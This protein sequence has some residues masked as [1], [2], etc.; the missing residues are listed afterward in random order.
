MGDAFEKWCEEKGG[1]LIVREIPVYAGKKEVPPWERRTIVRKMN[2]CLIEKDNVKMQFL[3][4][5]M[6]EEVAM[7]VNDK[8]EMKAMIEDI[9]KQFGRIG[10]EG[11]IEF[12]CREG[13]GQWATPGVSWIA[14][15]R[16]PVKGGREVGFFHSI[17]ECDAPASERITAGAIIKKGEKFEDSELEEFL[18]LL[19]EVDKFS[20]A[21]IL[22]HGQ[23]LPTMKERRFGL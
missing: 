9:Q 12:V 5:T 19:A 13:I 23:M 6:A 11:G 8:E 1:K 22:K 2:S 18:R 21:T 20:E 16:Y 14:Q 4:L 3:P 17:G 15:K 10:F 7:S